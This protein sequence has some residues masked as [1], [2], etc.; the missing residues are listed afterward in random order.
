VRTGGPMAMVKSDLVAPGLSMIAA[1]AGVR[2]PDRVYPYLD[3]LGRL[4]LIAFSRE[5]LDDMPAYQVLEAQPEVAA[6][7]ERAGRGKTVRRSIELTMFGRDFCEACLPLETSEIEAL[8][9][10][11]PE[12]RPVS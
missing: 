1:E 5:P 3:N 2:H 4:G 8:A 12:A 6:A 9:D 10:P 7:M 11:G